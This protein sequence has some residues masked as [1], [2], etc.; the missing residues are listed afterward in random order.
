MKSKN[1]LILRNLG[2][3]FDP[4][5]PSP[6]DAHVSHQDPQSNG[7]T[8]PELRGYVTATK[9]YKELPASPELTTI[10]LMVL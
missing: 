7:Q 6:A 10:H 9:T 5:K 2:F 1:G 4:R 3:L 8:P